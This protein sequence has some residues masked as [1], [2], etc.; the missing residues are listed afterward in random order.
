VGQ[1]AV[2][3]ASVSKGKR[4]DEKQED[5]RGAET[6]HNGK[7]Q[8]LPVSQGY[9]N[10]TFKQNPASLKFAHSIFLSLRSVIGPDELAQVPYHHRAALG[11]KARC[12]I[13]AAILV[14]ALRTVAALEG[15]GERTSREHSLGFTP[16]SEFQGAGAFQ[17]TIARFAFRRWLYNRFFPALL[18]AAHRLRAMAD[19]RARAAALTFLLPFARALRAKLEFRFTLA[20]RAFWAAAILALPA[21]L[22]VFLLV[23]A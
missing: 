15:N 21:A 11:P 3:V 12:K 6:G 19:N 1:F 17:L 10:R 5:E 2:S 14:I 22:I 13:R 8:Q 4:G 9:R 18:T 7:D 16:V 20:Q 23:A